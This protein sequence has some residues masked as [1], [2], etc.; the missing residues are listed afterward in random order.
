MKMIRCD[1]CGVVFDEP[2]V[3][4]HG[5]RL[6]PICC[7]SEVYFEYIEECSYCDGWKLEG[8]DMC[9]DC[10]DTLMEEVAAFLSRYDETQI[11][12]ID[13]QLDGTAVEDFIQRFSKKEA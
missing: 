7:A 3:N 4:K 6:C 11:S 2:Y 5:D 13:F 8:A 1:V 10:H 12:A 9:N